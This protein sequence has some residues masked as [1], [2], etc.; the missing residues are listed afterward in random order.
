MAF[1]EVL[2]KGKTR[3]A[4]EEADHCQY[5]HAECHIADGARSKTESGIGSRDGKHFENLLFLWY[6]PAG[7]FLNLFRIVTVY[8]WSIHKGYRCG[9]VIYSSSV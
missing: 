1:F 7:V 5:G 6:K 9:Q 8:E 2:Y 4:K 3:I